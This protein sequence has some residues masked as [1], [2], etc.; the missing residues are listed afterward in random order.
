MTKRVSHFL[1]NVYKVIMKPE[2]VILPGQ[3]AFYFVLSIVPTIS[4]ISYWASL[5][6]Y[7]SDFIYKFIS[8]AFSKDIATVLLSTDINVSSHGIGFIIVL[9]VAYYIA[10]NG[11]S[12]VIVTSNTIY[13]IK[14]KPF[15]QRR[16]KAFMMTFIMLLL[17]IF[18]LIVPVFGDML[19]DSI[20]SLHPHSI[21]IKILTILQS[22]VT[23]FIVYL[24]IKMI[25][26]MA[27][28]KKIKSHSVTYGA[29]FTTV[30]WVLG[31]AAY[32][33][34]INNYANY[35][36]FY[37]GLANL[38]ILMLW[39][40]YLAYFFTIGMALNYHKEEEESTFN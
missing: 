22:P 8:N 4:L 19:I 14:N 24:F 20:T 32:S 15:L 40:Y 27:P 34:Y 29:I 37:G 33:F 17:L 11:A 2:M 16:F 5:L 28:D 9:L 35:N 21:L 25:Y 18:L 36:A 30:C 3:L 7:P 13:G 6:K 23:W 39:F 1:Q 12:S 38:V 10:S 26:T 31:T